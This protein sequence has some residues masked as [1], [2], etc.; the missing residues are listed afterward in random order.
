MLYEY[1]L[2]NG[3]WKLYW[4]G[5]VGQDAGT[6]ACKQREVAAS[7]VAPQ[8]E[9]AAPRREEPQLTLQA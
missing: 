6:P 3:V 1:I 5:K 8:V 4:G 7:V 2:E 9:T